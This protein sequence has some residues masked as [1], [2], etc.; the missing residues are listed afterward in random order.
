M[1]NILPTAIHVSNHIL[2]ILILP[3]LPFPF[4]PPLCHLTVDSINFKNKNEQNTL[5]YSFFQTVLNGTSSWTLQGIK[6]K[7]RI[8]FSCSFQ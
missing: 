2:M 4:T 7:E 6:I 8:I 5:H 3:T 1:F